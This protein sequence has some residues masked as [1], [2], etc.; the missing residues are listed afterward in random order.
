MNE[1]LSFLEPDEI[2]NAIEIISKTL[3]NVLDENQLT[4]MSVSFEKLKSSKNSYSAKFND[5]VIVRIYKGAKKTHIELP[6]VGD[7][8]VP[9]AKDFR[10]IQLTSLNEVSEHLDKIICSFQY[11]LDHQP[12]DFSCCSRYVECSDKKTCIHPDKNAA[13]GCYYRK[14]LVS[15]RIFYG[16]NRNID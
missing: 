7:L 14:V 13:L 12:K 3:S 2:T 6:N 8:K 9:D 5:S 1:Q 16:Q 4:G 15:G 11:I 10:K